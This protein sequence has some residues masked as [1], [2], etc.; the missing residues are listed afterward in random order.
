MSLVFWRVYN[1]LFT[2]GGGGWYFNRKNLIFFRICTKPAVKMC[3]WLTK[4]ICKVIHLTS[5]VTK[6]QLNCEMNH[7]WFLAIRE[8]YIGVIQAIIQSLFLVEQK[9]FCVQVRNNFNQ[10]LCRF[11]VKLLL[12][13]EKLKPDTQVKNRL[14]PLPLHLEPNF[15]K[16]LLTLP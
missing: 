12:N 6:R 3:H 11:Q 1:L 14:F 7:Q 15:E 4:L 8:L 13:F 10:K 2:G 5:W 16:L 9:L